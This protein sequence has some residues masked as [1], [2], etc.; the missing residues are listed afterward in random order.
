MKVTMLL[1]LAMYLTGCGCE[2][3]DT[4]HRGIEK[5]FGEIQGDPL[6]EGLKFYNPITSTIVE[7]DI[8]EEKLEGKTP[9]YTKDTQIAEINYALTF[10]PDPA[11]IGDLYKNLG[12]EWPKKIVEPLVLDTIQ[13]VIGQVIADD[14]MANR[15]QTRLKAFAK[16]RDT[17]TE[18]HVFLTQLAFVNVDFDDAY[19]KA[20]EAKVVAIQKAAQAKNKTVEVEENAKQSIISA[21][22]EAESMQIRAAALSQNKGLVEYEAVQKWDGKLPVNMFGGATPF[23]NLTPSK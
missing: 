9:A 13:D 7:L 17:L 21:K 16:M 1:A 5:R 4:G 10:A 6:T 14:L 2:V 8:R 3:I 15:E 18:R 11:R 22:A 23:I 12:E 19:E 20:V